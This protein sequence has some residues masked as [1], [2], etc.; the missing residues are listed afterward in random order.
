MM[1]QVASSF[2]MMGGVWGG[3]AACFDNLINAVCKKKKIDDIQPD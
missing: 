2:I 1:D 3:C